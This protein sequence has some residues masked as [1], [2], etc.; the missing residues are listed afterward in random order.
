MAHPKKAAEVQSAPAE[1][2][3]LQRECERLVFTLLRQARE[4]A[5]VEG[6]SLPQLFLL[7]AVLRAGP[8]PVTQLT[9]WT[10]G[11]VSAI[12]GLL[13]GLVEAK[14]LLREHGVEDRR[15][16]LVS[17]SAE[18]RRLVDRVS[19][20]RVERWG[21]IDARIRV[22]DS[23]V[24]AKVIRE[25]VAAMEMPAPSDDLPHN[26]GPTLARPSGVAREARRVAA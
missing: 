16:V 25:V 8:V 20:R 19:S 23:K 17:L 2:S 22:S 9:G 4:D 7:G 11:S 26:D 15:Q 6:L 13:D 1:L 10:G 24:A 5:S 12:S 18:G 14:L 21:P 3:D